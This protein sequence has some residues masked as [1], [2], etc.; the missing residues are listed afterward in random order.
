MILT[1]LD[2]A[3]EKKKRKKLGESVEE[4]MSNLL[5]EVPTTADIQFPFFFFFFRAT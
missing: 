3:G 2:V 5:S 1:L 4:Q